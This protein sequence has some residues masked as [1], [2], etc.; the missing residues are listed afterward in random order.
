M[1]KLNMPIKRRWISAMYMMPAL[2]FASV[3]VGCSSDSD[4]SQSQKSV[5]A[6]SSVEKPPEQSATLPES[7]R[8]PTT[9]ATL[10]TSLTP[11]T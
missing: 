4:S 7:L 5:T 2:V 6:T 8:A 9:T 1:L 3:L 11:A 10:D